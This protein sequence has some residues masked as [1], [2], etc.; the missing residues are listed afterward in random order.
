MSD[1]KPKAMTPDEEYAF[2]SQPEN[3]VPERKPRRRAAR[4]S[5]PIPVRFSPALS[6]AIRARWGERPI[7]VGLDPARRGAR[8]R[9]ARVEPRPQRT[10]GPTWEACVWP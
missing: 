2:C 6:A 10:A 9:A 4:P 3:Q 8:V 1:A 5:E 7:G